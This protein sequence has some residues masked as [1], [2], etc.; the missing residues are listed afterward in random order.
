M[1]SKKCPSCG[2]EVHFDDD[3]CYACGANV[4]RTVPI[5]AYIVGGII[6]VAL[7]LGLVDWRYW[8]DYFS[9]F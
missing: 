4:P 8:I 5:M 9:G 3:K 6:A 7:F 1:N 2:T